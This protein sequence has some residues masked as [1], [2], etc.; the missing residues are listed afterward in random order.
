MLLALLKWDHSIFTALKH[1]DRCKDVHAH[2]ISFTHYVRRGGKDL[3]NRHNRLHR[4]NS[5]LQSSALLRN[6]SM[7]KRG[8]PVASTI[9]GLRIPQRPL[10]PTAEGKLQNVRLKYTFPN[11]PHFRSW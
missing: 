5:P 3:T 8:L 6:R 7:E 2:Y 9:Q 11:Y 1:L 4:E 10:P